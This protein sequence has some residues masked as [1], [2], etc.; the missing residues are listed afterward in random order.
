L[1][2]RPG[3]TSVATPCPAA[4]HSNPQRTVTTW[5][6]ALCCLAC[7]PVHAADHIDTDGPDY[8]ESTEVVGAGRLQFE[9]GP[10]LRNDTRN[11]ARLRT[12]STPLLLKAGLSETV[13]ARLE[14]DGY[15]RLYGTDPAGS[16]T[17]AR[18]G[19]ADTA[20][21]LKWHVHDQAPGSLAPTLAWIAHPEMPSGSAALRGQ[22][23]RPSL[24][25][26]LGWNLPF[27][28]SLGV[29]PGL[30]YESREDGHRFPSGILGVVLGRWWTP[31]LRAF[32]ESSAERIARQENGGV[33]LYKD[34][35]AAYLLT[36]NWQLGGRAGWAANRNTPSR[37]V[38]LSLAARF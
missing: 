9:T 15:A 7:Q 14:T 11:G 21:G 23:L 31:R 6:I 37:Y 28:M 19:F 35:G 1:E 4:N 34:V 18:S 13:E 3:N 25:A 26:V 32:I 10:Y 8:V 5:A 20:L 38:M 12:S 24:R 17:L 16:P 33:V 2:D 29:M 27:G 36:D 30:K 22:G